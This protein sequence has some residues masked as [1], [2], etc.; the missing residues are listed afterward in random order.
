[1]VKLIMIVLGMLLGHYKI[2]ASNSSKHIASMGLA[3]RGLHYMDFRDV[4]SGLT[5]RSSGSKAV[6]YHIMMLYLSRSEAMSKI[7]MLP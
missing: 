3:T 5:N 7:N 6:C 2:L 1:M 4:R